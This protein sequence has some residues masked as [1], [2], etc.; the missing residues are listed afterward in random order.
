MVIRLKEKIALI[1]SGDEF[2]EG[3]EEVLQTLKKENVKAS[4]FFTGNFY[5]NPS[6]TKLIQHIKKDGHYLGAHSDKHL[7]YC[8]WNKRD[9]LF[10]TKEQF[11]K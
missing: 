1:F 2:A 11:E 6:F 10:V 5:R 8:D 7:L 3:G 4:F 9:S